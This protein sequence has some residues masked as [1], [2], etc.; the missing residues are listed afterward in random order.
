MD[1]KLSNNVF[2]R[3][4]ILFLLSTRRDDLLLDKDVLQSMWILRNHTPMTSEEAM[5]FLI[6]Q[7]KGTKT[8]EEFL[9]A[10]NSQ[11]SASDP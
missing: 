5:N 4:L 7:M 6:V 1:R 9:V 10:M 2:I 11:E 8:N 3:L